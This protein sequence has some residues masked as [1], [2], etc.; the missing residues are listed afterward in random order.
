MA[1]RSVGISITISGADIQN[2]MAGFRKLNWAVQRK[3]LDRSVK[4]TIAPAVPELRAIA[5]KNKGRLSR[6]AGF[7]VNKMKKRGSRKRMVPTKVFGR[8][9]FKY[10]KTAKGRSRGGY[11]AHWIEQG[12]AKRVPKRAKT[13][14]IPWAKNRKYKYLKPLQRSVLVRNQEAGGEKK[15]NLVFLPETK[16]IKGRHFFE[17]WVRINNRIFLATLK[18]KL[19][20]NLRKAIAESR[21]KA[22]KIAARKLAKAKAGA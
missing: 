2:V 16:P 6:A 15:T 22:R 9:G 14:A 1:N 19:K 20:S 13:F 11:A 17:R 3:Y 12:V 18:G 10:G 5:P 8:L 7:V 4:E 21:V